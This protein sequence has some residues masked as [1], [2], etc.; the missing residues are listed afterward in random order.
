MQ[1]HSIAEPL[2]DHRVPRLRPH[3]FGDTPLPGMLV[4]DLAWSLQGASDDGG[5]GV[6]PVM[7]GPIP[8]TGARG[9]S[10]PACTHA[11]CMLNVY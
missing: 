8:P 3:E 7:E 9:S 11:N 10:A 6:A 2:G 1:E 5:V 4:P